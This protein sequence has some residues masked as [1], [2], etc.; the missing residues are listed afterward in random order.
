MRRETFLN[1]LLLVFLW[2]RCGRLSLAAQTNAAQQSRAAPARNLPRKTQ[3]TA[4]AGLTLEQL[5]QLALANNPTLAQAKAGVRAAAGR[6]RQAGLWP[7][8]TIGYQRRRNSRRIVRRRRAGSVRAAKR[9]S[10]RET[11]SRP[12]NFRRGRQA[13][14]G[15]S[16]RTAPARGKRSAHRFLP[17]AGDA[18]DGGDARQAARYRQRRG[19]NHAPAFQC[20]P[21]GPARRAGSGRGSGS[22]RTRGDHRAAGATARVERAGG[23]GRQ[24]GFAAR[25]SGGRPGKTAGGERGANFANDFAR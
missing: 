7:N 10:R 11:R 5:Q 25:A 13:S 9:D 8:P 18:S 20:R 17:I 6:T 21:G 1:L 23:G 24:A 2:A 12:E 4:D 14:G 22:R 3:P 16:R 15:G 19:R